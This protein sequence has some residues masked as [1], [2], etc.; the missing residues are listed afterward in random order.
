MST[1]F[2]ATITVEVH[3]KFSNELRT[4]PN[5]RPVFNLNV[6]VSQ[7]WTDKKSNERKE[8]VQWVSLT[9]F[10]A[11]AENLAKHAKPGAIINFEVNFLT[12]R[13]YT[14]TAGEPAASINLDVNRYNVIK[15]APRDGEGTFE[16]DQPPVNM[17]EIPF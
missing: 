12:A 4:M 7:S 8:R 16:G 2:N 3:E 1:A 6:P 15:W 5:G 11:Q 9:A 17:D 10:D 14:N 13:A